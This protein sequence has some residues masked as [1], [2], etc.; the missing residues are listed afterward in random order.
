MTTLLLVRHPHAKINSPIKALLDQPEAGQVA[1]VAGAR[2]AELSGFGQFQNAKIAKTVWEEY[3]TDIGF[4]EIIVLSAPLIRTKALYPALDDLAAADTDNSITITHH[5]VDGFNARGLGRI[6]G[7]EMGEANNMV[8]AQPYHYQFNP[9]KGLYLAVAGASYDNKTVDDK[10]TDRTLLQTSKTDQ[11]EQVAPEEFNF[12]NDALNFEPAHE[13]YARV[14]SGIREHLIPALQQSRALVVHSFT[15]HP[16]N[17][18]L[19]TMGQPR[20]K[21]GQG[22]MDSFGVFDEW[23]GDEWNGQDGLSELHDFPTNDSCSIDNL[24]QFYREHL[25]R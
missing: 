13:F 17:L 7:V 10:T 8:K 9:E 5:V 19:D 14:Q 18:I 4:N 11:G 6:E 12:E 25:A 3:A 24:V 15:T 20:K 16:Y 23:N 22:V 21:T 2:D 1:K